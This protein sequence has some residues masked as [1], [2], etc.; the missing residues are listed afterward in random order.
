MP[1]RWRSGGG[2]DP[3]CESDPPS[4]PAAGYRQRVTLG[5]VLTLFYGVILALQTQSPLLRFLAVAVGLL[6][7]LIALYLKFRPDRAARS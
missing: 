1:R 7:L 4:R 3:G 6:V 5:G 2:F